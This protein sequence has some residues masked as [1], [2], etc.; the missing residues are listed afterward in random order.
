MKVILPESNSTFRPDLGF[1]LETAIVKHFA[2][3]LYTYVY[4]LVPDYSNR[5]K[6]SRS[7][8]IWYLTKSIK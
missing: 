2:V 3:F 7:A 6:R 4:V 1:L 5:T 8:I